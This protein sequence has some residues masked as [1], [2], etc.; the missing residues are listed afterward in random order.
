MAEQPADPQTVEGHS[1]DD[2]SPK[3]TPQLEEGVKAVTI[4]VMSLLADA[5]SSLSRGLKEKHEYNMPR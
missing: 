1:A 4:A 5:P 2:S 3:R